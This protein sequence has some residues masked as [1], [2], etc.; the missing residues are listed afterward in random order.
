MAP[1]TS[2]SAARERILDAASAA[3]YGRGIGAVGVDVVVAE[4]GVA[5]ATLY[6]HFRSKDDLVVAFLRRRDGRWRDWLRSAAERL[7]PRPADR[8][9]A[10]FDAL[11]EWFASEDFRG[12]AFI[13]AAAEIADPEHPARAA[14]EDHERLLAIDLE[15]MLS[16]AGAA[17]PADDAAALLLLIQGAIVSAL[18]ERDAAPAA[19]ARSAAARILRAPPSRESR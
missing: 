1:A 2:P 6:R 4:A 5:K 7:A 19:R 13:N 10:V 16:A 15:D 8:P 14:V 17:D 18:I 11:G 3:F 12:C 9:L